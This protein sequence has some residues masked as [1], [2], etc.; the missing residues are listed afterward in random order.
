M[1][2]GFIGLKYFLC[3]DGKTGGKMKMCAL[4]HNIKVFVPN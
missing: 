2:P 4:S 1:C 3:A